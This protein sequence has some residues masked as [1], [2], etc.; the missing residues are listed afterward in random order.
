MVRRDAAAPPRFGPAG[1]WAQ[2]GRLGERRRIVGWTLA[3]ACSIAVYLY[4]RHLSHPSMVDLVVYRAEGLAVREGI[5][6]YGPLNTPHGLGATYP[7]FAAILFVPFT[8][9]PLRALLGVGVAVNLL[10]VAVVVR[11]SMRLVD[12][13][14]RR[15]GPAVVPAATTF[16]IWFEPVFTTMRYG[17]VNLA[18][19]AMVLWDFTRPR[20]AP[21]RGAVLGIATGIKVTPAVFVVYLLLTGR[22]REAGT[23]LATA[24]ATVAFSAMML[25]GVT[26]RFWTDLVFD[27]DR[28]GRL[29]N[30]ANQS[31][32]G[33]LTRLAGT[34]DLGL[35]WSAVIVGLSLLGLCGALIAYRRRGDAWGLPACAAT[36]L[37]AS[38]ISWS[39]HW[40]W[41]VPIALLLW[42]TVHGPH[43]RAHTALFAGLLVFPSFLVWSVPHLP[44]QEWHMTDFELFR[45]SCYVAYGVAFVLVAAGT[46]RVRPTRVPRSAAELTAGIRQ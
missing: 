23:A 40:V 25:P 5:D 30:A 31:I 29:E 26:R 20:G 9:L 27:P 28:V 37:L 14:G 24:A 4:V 6:L 43:T 18:V 45:S 16:A 11:L 42:T 13:E 8:Y 12:P 3:C 39:H 21:L 1:A 22:R 46:A 35:G 33:L 36:G 44:D 17:Q 2:W 10:L 15:L 41:C 32:R 38:P 34:R 19:A 7:P